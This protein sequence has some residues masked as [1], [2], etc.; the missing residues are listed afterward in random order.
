MKMQLDMDRIARG[1]GA[2]RRGKIAARGGYFGAMQ[3]WPTS[4]RA[5]AYLRVEA[6]RQTPA[7]PSDGS[8]PLRLGR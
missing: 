4:R 8:C 2:E 6:G 1:L 7:G 5:S 3:L